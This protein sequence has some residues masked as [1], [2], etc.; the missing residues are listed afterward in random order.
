VRPLMVTGIVVFIA[1]LA[2]CSSTEIGFDTLP[3]A[4]D[5]LKWPFANYSIWNL[6][7]GQNAKY[8]FANIIKATQWGM[9]VD[10]DIIIL[11]PNDPETDIYYNSDAWSG[12]SRCNREGGLLFSGPMPANFVIPGAGNGNTPNYAGAIL[13]KDGHTIVQGQPLARCTA[14]GVVTALVQYPS[15]DLY[16]DGIVGAHGGSGMSS[17]GGT[18]RLGELTPSSGPIRHALKINLNGPNYYGSGTPA[19]YRWP[20]VKADSCVPG[21]YT[22]HNT[23]VKMGTL[24]ALNASVD[25]TKMGFE[26]EPGRRLAWTFQNYGSY[27]VDST[28]W[29]VYALETEQSPD[30]DMTQEFEKSWGFSM[31]P[32]DRSDPFASDM[33]KIFLNLYAVDNWD[34]TTWKRVI[35]SNGNEGAGGG[36]PRQPWAPPF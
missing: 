5:P 30:G 28:G 23:A 6:P 20:A 22:G 2:S 24:M 7:I 19:G 31:T 12:K 32:Q 13:K 29:N 26:T 33:D 8:V 27:I 34:A 3:T 9:T 14:G 4:R 11:T 1:L 18:I 15:V 21:C 25:I 35:V 36:A 10:P 16:G 17:I